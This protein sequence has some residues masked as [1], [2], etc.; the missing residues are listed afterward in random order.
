MQ[1]ELISDFCC[2]AKERKSSKLT[3]FKIEICAFVMKRNLVDHVVLLLNFPLYNRFFVFDISLT[4]NIA[5]EK[6]HGFGGMVRLMCNLETW[7]YS[8]L[9]CVCLAFPW[10]SWI[11]KIPC[12]LCI[13]RT[14]N[15]DY[16]DVT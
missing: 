3:F 8:C 4:N 10:H 15:A 1:I 16:T 2:R 13:L 11:L 5:D 7:G 14:A 6:S 12:I 9:I